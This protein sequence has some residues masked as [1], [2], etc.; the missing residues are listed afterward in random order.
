MKPTNE[1]LIAGVFHRDTSLTWRDLITRVQQDP[2]ATRATTRDEN[3]AA[4]H[5]ACRDGKVAYFKLLLARGADPDAVC[6]IGDARKLHVLHTIF[7]GTGEESPA[8]L[9]IADAAMQAGACIDC[10]DARG[11]TPLMYAASLDFP[12]F[13]RLL[14]RRGAKLGW[15][16]GMYGIVAENSVFGIA[17]AFKSRRVLAVLFQEGCAE[18]REIIL[19]RVVKRANEEIAERNGSSARVPV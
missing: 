11:W 9:Q 4:S 16:D 3:M 15:E 2:S 10:V 6:H 12:N 17:I 19:D 13:A 1:A 5:V 14:I 7:E 8:R 18:F